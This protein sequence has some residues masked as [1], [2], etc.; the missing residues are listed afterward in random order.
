[1][2][3][4]AGSLAL[5]AAWTTWPGAG[6]ASRQ[7]GWAP[8]GQAKGASKLRDKWEKR[9]KRAGEYPFEFAEVQPLAPIGAV[10][11]VMQHGRRLGTERTCPGVGLCMVA[12]GWSWSPTGLR[13][14]RPGDRSHQVMSL[15]FGKLIECDDDDSVTP[16][17]TRSESGLGIQNPSENV[18]WW[19]SH[20]GIQHQCLRLRQC[21]GRGHRPGEE[22]GV[23][24]L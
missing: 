18:L 19:L 5:S 14:Q 10:D 22:D 6:C 9:T 23:F 7:D 2:G 11:V 8:R 1:M 15:T 21:A 12:L 16:R 17:G 3:C 24:A 4:R 13:A 20:A